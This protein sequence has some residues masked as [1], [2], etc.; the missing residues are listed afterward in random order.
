[1]NKIDEWIRIVHGVYKEAFES[2][3]VGN[4]SFCKNGLSI[5]SKISVRGH[6]SSHKD[7]QTQTFAVN[8]NC[9]CKEYGM[10]WGCADCYIEWKGGYI[11]AYMHFQLVGGCVCICTHVHTYVYTR[12]YWKEAYQTAKREL[13][14][15]MTIFFLLFFQKLDYV[16]L[17]VSITL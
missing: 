14:L 16:I 6:I 1:M 7:R 2:E 15:Q 3:G 4:M 11:R 17:K 9:V 5:S 12:I 13:E 8:K 10:V